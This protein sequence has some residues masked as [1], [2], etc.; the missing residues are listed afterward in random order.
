MNGTFVSIAD[1]LS[2]R[3]N[4]AE[5]QKMLLNKYNLPL[6]SFTM[7]IAGEIKR[8]S[9]IDLAFKAGCEALENALGAPVEKLVTDENTGIEAIYVY[10]RSA[11]DLKAV[12]VELE[13][14]PVGRLYDMDVINADGTKLSRGEMRKCIVC[15]NAVTLCSR[16][17]AHGLDTIKAKTQ[18]LLN[19]FASE[20]IGDRAVEAMLLEARLTPKPGLVDAHDCGAHTDMNLEL[21]IKSAESLRDFLREAARL[22]MENEHCMAELKAA[23]IAAEKQMFAVTGGINTHKGALYALSLLCAG[24]GCSLIRGTDPFE[25]AAQLARDGGN[26]EAGSHGEAVRAKFGKSGAR[27]EAESGFPCVKAGLAELH[28]SGDPLRALLR[29]ISVCNDTNLLHRGGEEGLAYTRL[30]AKKALGL[31]GRE[32]EEYLYSIN[33][34]MIRRNLSPGGSADMLSCAVFMKSVE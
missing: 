33:R 10:R 6:V 19:T 18:E 17:R 21:L 30:W 5:K 14:T 27:V 2:A 20:Y 11:E 4:R 29:I 34:E 25:T 13:S 32:R 31:Q 15:G 26:V 1:V 22:G 3:E 12:C 24:V 9:L 16:S 23:G 8:S 7:N 28:A